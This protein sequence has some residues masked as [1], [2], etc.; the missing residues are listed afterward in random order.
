MSHVG[1]FV[2]IDHAADHPHCSTLLDNTTSRCDEEK[3]NHSHTHSHRIITH[4]TLATDIAGVRKAITDLSGIL[5]TDIN[6]GIPSVKTT[7]TALDTKLTA[8]TKS[9]NTLT[10]LVN[11]LLKKDC[12]LIDED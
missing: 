3:Y 12:L 1:G 5:V 4:A 2:Y 6:V 9:V 10:C 8:L 7:L 11:K